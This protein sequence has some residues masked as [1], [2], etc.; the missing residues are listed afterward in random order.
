MGFEH[1]LPTLYSH[2]EGVTVV[3][4]QTG[5]LE[6]VVGV[7]VE[8]VVGGV[9][10]VTGGVVMVLELDESGGVPH[11]SRDCKSLAT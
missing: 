9:V 7:V 6:V 11:G 3:A 1:H 8:L 4:V 2:V 10:V 5:A